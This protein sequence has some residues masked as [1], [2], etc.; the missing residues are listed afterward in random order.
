MLPPAPPDPPR[1]G[2]PLAAS[3]APVIVSLGIWA[4]T[5]SPY[6]LLF[7]AL[8]PVV[9]LGSLL[10]GRRARRRAARR[11]RGRA[12]AALR[13]TGERIEQ[14]HRLERE[15]LEGLGPPISVALDARRVLQSWTRAAAGPGEPLGVR[16]GRAELPPVV[17]LTGETDEDAPPELRTAVAGLRRAASRLDAAPLLLDAADGIGVLGP[18][19]AARAVARCLAVSVLAQRSPAHTAVTAP[20][21][22][23]WIA[24]APH[25]VTTSDEDAYRF[26]GVGSAVPS[27]VIAWGSSEDRV[28]P[29][30]G[31]T[32]RLG[33]SSG[34]DHLAVSATT[35]REAASSLT[36]IAARH[37]VSDPSSELPD[38]VALRALL[39]LDSEPA[40]E[41]GVDRG[42]EVAGDRPDLRAPIGVGAGGILELDLVRDGPHAVVAGTTGA[43][44]SE[45]LVSWVL[46]MAT[47]YPP[48]AVTFLLVDFK[49]GAAFTPF[50]GVP[51]V[52]GIVSDLDGRRSIRAIDSLRAELH[53]REVILADQGVR[54]VEEAVGLARLVI[55]VDEFA[56]VVSGRPELHDVFA[57]LAAR[58]RSLGLHLVLCT[59]RPSG[60]VRDGVLANVTLRISLRVL[61]R[62]DSLAMV[63]TDAAAA[64]ASAP[65]GRAVVV[66][67]SGVV[68]EV[69]L[70][71]AEAGDA[72]R[73]RRRWRDAPRAAAIWCDP[74]PERITLAELERDR[75]WPRACG[76][77][78]GR[79]DLPAQQ[80]QPLAVHDPAVDGHLLILGAAR[81]GRTTALATFGSDP[82]CI[83]LPSDPA[84]AWSLLD[85]LT[86]HP[87]AAEHRVLLI[88]DLD[89]L[90]DRF[91]VELR[92]EFVERLARLAR[93]SRRLGLIV[94]VQRLSSSLQRL[95]P[96]LDARVVL[97]Q[98][99][100]DEH[101]LSGA[102]PGSYDP[103]LPPGAGSWYSRAAAASAASEQPGVHA[104]AH[105]AARHGVTVQLAIGDGPPPTAAFPELPRIRVPADGTGG[106]PVAIVAARP[107][108]LIQ[109][110]AGH[111]TNGL[112]VV[113]VGE[114][115]APGDDELRVSR[116]PVVLLGDPDAWQSEWALLTAMR[117]ERPLLFVGCTAADVRAVARLRD[118]PPPLGRR[119]GECW[120]VDGGL[121]RRA[122]LE[123]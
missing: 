7:A 49:G 26:G 68:R 104:G 90:V 94:T 80:R 62:G 17:E 106:G 97:R 82:R 117:R 63:G 88:D 41:S 6:S 78:F 101:V 105:A 19:V 20:A 42:L 75:D 60:V 58:G 120:L 39:E 65:R 31:H 52:V 107:R 83:L 50:A 61:D 119:P 87:V 11:D 114:E 116:G 3:L 69:Q 70:A 18:P 36:E 99:S 22:E 81:S 13:R 76:I 67:G 72:E 102:D 73:V 96:L 64:L 110:L 92:H 118:P 44:K 4:A 32:V 56:A 77:P 95:A 8:G 98:P 122:L 121:V 47:R 33:D 89:L 1:A 2:F 109:R 93:E 25:R 54:S 43:G 28:P 35:A 16:L 40:P 91:E 27:V 5:G 53:R 15:R 23:S 55:V 37:G 123:L 59:Q 21:S 38:E 71:L 85:D 46:A 103:R 113:R 115:P 112:R 86:A 30:L 24:G 100:R 79:M 48:S 51:H 14:L 10:D 9:A 34:V 111:A 12:L 66:D 108:D 29:D 57:D 84:D 45:L 74:L